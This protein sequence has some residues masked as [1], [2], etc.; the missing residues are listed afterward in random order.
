MKKEIYLYKIQITSKTNEE[1]ND[2][3]KKITASTAYLDFKYIDKEN[4]KKYYFLQAEKTIPNYYFSLMKKITH[5]NASLLDDETETE[6]T[7]QIETNEFIRFG[8]HLNSNIITIIKRGNFGMDQFTIAFKDIYTNALKKEFNTEIESIEFIPVSG[9]PSSW[10][11]T[12]LM[13]K[14]KNLDYLKEF[15]ANFYSKMEQKEEVKKE[16]LL[17]EKRKIKLLNSAHFSTNISQLE[18]IE[19]EYNKYLEKSCYEKV[20]VICKDIKN[21]KFIINSNEILTYSYSGNITKK[22]KFIEKTKD[23][24]EDYILNYLNK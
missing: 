4:N 14:I 7:E 23:T 24:I 13:E 20:E 8:I 6:T 12:N 11:E 16:I 17:V 19:K 9:V 22:E 2:I 15:E 3:L 18:S 10:N 1:K 21:Q 5:L